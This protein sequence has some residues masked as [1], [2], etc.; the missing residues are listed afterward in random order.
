MYKYSKSIAVA[1]VALSMG[2]VS[3]S[4]DDDNDGNGNGSSTEEIVNPAEVFTQ[5]LPSQIGDMNI[6]TN[7]KGQVSE[8]KDDDKT[9][10]F[11]YASTARATEYDMTMEVKWRDRPEEWVKFYIIAVR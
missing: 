9:I 4:D 8:I 11:Q 6:T 10:S 5:G 3:C 1:L 2:F 7:A